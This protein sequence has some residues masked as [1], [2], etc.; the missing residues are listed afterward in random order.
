MSPV[1]PIRGGQ[2]AATA[3]SPPDD[4]PPGEELSGQGGLSWEQLADMGDLDSDEMGPIEG[5]S[6]S[7]ALPLKGAATKITLEQA[8]ERIGPQ[9]LQALGEYFNG[10][11]VA[12][13]PPDEKD[14]L[15]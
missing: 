3:E 8:T 6:P 2:A 12:V 11:L 5:S 9:V 7:L 10:S 1:E 15:F 13:R 14:H 4:A